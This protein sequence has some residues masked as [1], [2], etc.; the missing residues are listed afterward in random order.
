MVIITRSWS[1]PTSPFD[2]VLVL[3][4]I[5]ISLDL[6]CATIAR[7]LVIR[8]LPIRIRYS[9]PRP[10]IHFN[11]LICLVWHSFTFH[12]RHRHFNL[13]HH[14]HSSYLVCNTMETGLSMT[15][16]DLE[17][18]LLSKILLSKPKTTQQWAILVDCCKKGLLK[19]R[20]C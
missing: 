5:T 6:C 8:V 1:R 15:I 16:N 14:M 3:D 11:V 17:N 13:C 9:L 4:S 10:F 7:S 12:V 2:S 18:F 19:P 20:I